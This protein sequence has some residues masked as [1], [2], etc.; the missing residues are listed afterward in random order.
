MTIETAVLRPDQDLL[1]MLTHE[2]EHQTMTARI[3]IMFADHMILAADQGS[4]LGGAMNEPH[5]HERRT[6]LPVDTIVQRAC[7]MAEALVAELKRREHIIS[8]PVLSE[9]ITTKPKP[10]VEACGTAE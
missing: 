9:I 2:T 7:N 10:E 3:A 5:P 1:R 4:A 6:L 8:G